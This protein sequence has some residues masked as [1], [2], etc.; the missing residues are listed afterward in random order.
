MEKALFSPIPKVSPSKRVK[1]LGVTI[2]NKLSF[3]SHINDLCRQ[4]NLKSKAL[5]RI[6][7][8]IDFD[9]AKL[10][11]NAYILSS[12]NYCPLIWM[13]YNK[14]AENKINRA[15]LRALR[16]IYL[17]F[18]SN[19]EELLVKDGGVK[20][21]AKNNQILACEVFKSLNEINP[22]YMWDIFEEKCMP[23]KLRAGMLLTLPPANTVTYGLN[24]LKL[25]FS[26]NQ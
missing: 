26:M 7:N 17:D 3:D 4:V 2:D 16:T 6:R 11:C 13:L 18:D 21:H 24:S 8:Y 1:L 22:E 19:L 23:Y 14:T 20:I 9:K 12:F 25:F 10:L 15:H 5:L